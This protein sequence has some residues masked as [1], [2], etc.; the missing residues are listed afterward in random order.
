MR[1]ALSLPVLT[2]TGA[3]LLAGCSS[4]GESSSAETPSASATSAAASSTGTDTDVVGTI[5][6][7]PGF[8]VAEPFGQTPTIEFGSDTPPE[9]LQVAATTVGEGAQVAPGAFVVVNYAGMV[10]GSDATFDSSFERSTA[11]AFSLSGVVEGWG[12]GLAGQT[13]GSRVLISIPPA[14]GYGPAG[15]N[16]GAGIGAE[17]TIVFVVDIIASYDGTSVGQADAVAT[18]AE[19]PVAITGEIGQPITDVQVAA[20]T[21]EPT[22]VTTTVL[23]T[24]TGEPV[25]TGQE[26]IV[27][28]ALN[29]WDNSA[30]ETSWAP[31]A[32]GPSTSLSVVEGYPFA[33]LAGVPLGSRVLVTVPANETSATPSVAFVLDL[34]G[35]IPAN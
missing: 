13:V 19:V 33:G 14:L 27:Q 23:A 34:L 24:G 6:T 31:A 22:E 3:L 11:S 16:E 2:L 7:D 9:G 21:P 12:T 5:G 29:V 10:W 8:T 26:L 1:R 4:D 25:V 15:G 28:Y 32:A 17:D 30:F 20:G 35:T 18:G